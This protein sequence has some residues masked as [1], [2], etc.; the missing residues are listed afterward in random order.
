MTGIDFLRAVNLGEAPAIGTSVAVIGGGNVA[1]D[2][3]RAAVRLGAEVTVVY[4]RDR[5]S[6]PAA[7]D[8]IAEAAE[9]GVS[10]RFLASPAEILGRRQSGNAQDRA[11]GAAGRKARRHRRL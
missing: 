2:V 11:H 1:I 10:F 3:A 5:D 9:E 6:M 8:E 4:R 7:D